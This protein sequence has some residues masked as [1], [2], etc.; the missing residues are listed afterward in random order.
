MVLTEIKISM[1]KITIALIMMDIF[2]E[3]IGIFNNDN[4]CN[5]HD[6]NHNYR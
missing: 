6:R 4:N 1:E 3:I 2:L 5:A